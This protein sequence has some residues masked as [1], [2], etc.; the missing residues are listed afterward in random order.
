MT[1]QPTPRTQVQIREVIST[2]WAEN[3]NVKCPICAEPMTQTDGY[4]WECDVEHCPAE[5]FTFNSRVHNYGVKNSTA[6]K[7]NAGTQSGH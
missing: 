1:E 5:S 6:H 3:G 7:Y 2:I 4:L